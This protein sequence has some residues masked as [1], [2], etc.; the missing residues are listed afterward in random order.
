MAVKK[1]E[2]YQSLYASCDK[3]RGSM[4]PSQYKNYILTLLFVK[5]IS[6]KYVGMKYAPIQIPDGCTFDDFAKLRH[7]PNIGEKI[8]KALA[9]LS[10]S[11]PMLNGVFNDVHFNDEAKMGSG[12]EMVSKISDLIDIFLRP[13]FDFRKNKASGDD[14]L[15]D[16]YEYLMRQ[17]AVESGKSKGQFYTPAEA[18]RVLA[19]VVG[20]SDISDRPEEPWSVYDPACGSG[21]LLIRA[22][23]EAGCMVSIFGQEKDLT[24]AGLAKM[25]M[26]IHNCEGAEIKVGNTFSQPQFTHM[27]DGV[28]VLDRFDFAVV[29]PPFSLRNWQ[30]G[31]KN[32]GRMDGY[33]E[34]PPEKNGDYAW[35]MHIIKSLKNNGRASVILPLGV[36]FRGNAEGVIRKSIVDKRLIEGIIAFPPNIFFGTGIP[37]CVLVI[38]KAEATTRDGIFMIDASRDF[39]KDG[40]KNRLRERDIEK[41]VSTYR[42]RREEPHYSRF[43]QWGEIRKNDY[44]L[45]IPRYIDSGVREDVQDIA[46]HLKGGIPSTDID[47]LGK[48]WEVFPRLR[49]RL[50]SR[51]REGYEKLAV[52]VDQT[53]D[54]IREDE[55]FAGYRGK[56]ETA[57]QH[58]SVHFDHGCRMLAET[59]DPKGFI[60]EQS[61]GLFQI[62]KLEEIDLLDPFDVYEVLLSYWNQ[63]MADDAYLISQEG[64]KVGGEIE[65]FTKETVS[66]KTGKSKVTVIGWDGKIIPRSLLDKELFTAETKALAEAEAAAEAAKTAL[67]EYLE[68]VTEEDDEDEVAAKQKEL[69]A[70]KK[71]AAKKANELA[72]E[73]EAKERAA[74]GKFTEDELRDFIIEKKWIAAVKD[75]IYSLYTA[76]SNRLSERITE[77]AERYSSTLSELDAEGER[78]EAEFAANLTKMGYCAMQELLTGKKRLPGFSGEWKELS[79]GSIGIWLKGQ[80]FAKS[81]IVVSGSNA[82]IHYGEL[83]TIY[84]PVIKN[85]ISKTDSECL[86]ASKIGDVLFPIS[87]VTPEGLGRC[88]V[89]LED[90]VLLGGDLL[91]L[92]PQIDVDSEMLS[93][94]INMN[95]RKIIELVTGTTVRHI[96][97]SALSGIK[98]RL[99]GSL[100]EQQAIA[101]VLSGMDAEIANLERKLE[102]LKLMKQGMMQDLLTGKVRLK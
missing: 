71:K 7:D 41:I 58:W 99:P 97:S 64:F 55:A 23:N 32:M 17:F 5:Y 38:S 82:C 10:E 62:F 87:D 93:Y 83:F 43:V 89:I 6:D 73:L 39:V 22:A 15:G 9:S 61:Q 90:G 13:E 51:F 28:E 74:Y 70:A 60:K 56:I 37:A 16:T 94:V 84:G 34:T 14:I 3:L 50:F 30:D 49:G 88:S 95:K 75:G 96:S 68:S 80:P 76:V 77:L 85:V 19:G 1:S 98:I 8:D 4:D 12:K 69:E 67:D 46:A 26:V 78:L 66:K 52:S 57:L 11:T 101:K 102:K 72:A 86:T 65:E 42:E 27:E 20:I 18:S 48:Y 63:T 45:N 31:F 36:L 44:N 40:N 2:I 54:A 59:R 92:R 47:Q 25:N 33:G 21:S 81:E 91:I 29:N 24:T 79:I 35:L 100:A 53:R